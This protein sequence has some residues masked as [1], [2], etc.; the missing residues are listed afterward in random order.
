MPNLELDL[1]SLKV[2]STVYIDLCYFIDLTISLTYY[3][4]WSYS[5]SKFLKNVLAIIDVPV[6]NVRSI[7]PYLFYTFF[8][9]VLFM[10]CILK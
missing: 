9:K 8:G 10:F 6:S 1:N 3:V 4:A 7:F 5:L 2:T